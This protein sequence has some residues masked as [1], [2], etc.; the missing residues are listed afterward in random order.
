ML[1]S[2][3]TVRVMCGPL[4]SITH[5]ARSAMAASELLSG[6]LIAGTNLLEQALRFPGLK[7]EPG[8]PH[9]SGKF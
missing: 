6:L 3:R 2:A 1:S 8:V 4:L 9:A 5:S 7:K